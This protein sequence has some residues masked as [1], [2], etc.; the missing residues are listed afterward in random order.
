MLKEVPWFLLFWPQNTFSDPA[1]T[2]AEW[3]R[4]CMGRMPN[5]LPM[6]GG[7]PKGTQWCLQE[8]LSISIGTV[9]LL[10]LG[11]VLNPLLDIGFTCMRTQV[12]LVWGGRSCLLV[13]VDGDQ[14]GHGVAADE[15]GEILVVPVLQGVDD[16]LLLPEIISLEIKLMKTSCLF[17]KNFSSHFLKTT[18]LPLLAPLE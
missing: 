16:L 15:E 13:V 1:S 17:D 3:A 7:C 8:K 2:S 10:S 11:I 5:T 6:R 18:W 12:S 14:L 9:Y 4:S